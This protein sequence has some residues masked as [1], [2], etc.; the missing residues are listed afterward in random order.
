MPITRNGESTVSHGLGRPEPS[1]VGIAWPSA[2]DMI[3]APYP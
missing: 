1:L 3:L 2:Y